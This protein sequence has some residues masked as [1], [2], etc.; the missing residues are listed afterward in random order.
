MPS[1]SQRTEWANTPNLLA[2]AIAVARSTGAELLDLSESN[3]TRCGL[4]YDEH[5]ILQ[6]FQNAGMLAYAPD[7]RGLA[8]ARAAVA[9]YYAEHGA[10]VSADDII[11]TT[12]T[13]EA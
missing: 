9:R 7:P 8:S 10:P 4:R 6:A 11:L 5:A 12:S 1:F 13:S 3:P 2:Q